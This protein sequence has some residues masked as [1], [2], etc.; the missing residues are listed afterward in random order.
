MAL[1]SHRTFNVHA[2]L[3]KENLEHVKRPGFQNKQIIVKIVGPGRK[4][5]ACLVHTS[6]LQLSIFVS[7]KR[8]RQRM[9]SDRLVS[10]VSRVL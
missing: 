10:G 8:A 1:T 4:R 9:K 5:A 6:E 3:S 2:V 7:L